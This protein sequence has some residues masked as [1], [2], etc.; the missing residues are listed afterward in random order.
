MIHCTNYLFRY[1]SDPP[2]RR[3]FLLCLAV[4]RRL[5]GWKT[6]ILSGNTG[7]TLVF[8]FLLFFTSRL[9]LDCRV[10]VCF[11]ACRSSNCTIVHLF[12]VISSPLPTSCPPGGGGAGPP[13]GHRALKQTTIFRFLKVAARLRGDHAEV[14][15]PSA[16][17]VWLNSA[18]R[19]PFHFFVI[20]MTN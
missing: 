19:R 15:T 4:F 9:N 20:K 11:L 7:C 2:T 10:L 3:F 17:Q 14:I 8:S 12:S 13:G 18:F 16:L 5:L 6:V 1:A